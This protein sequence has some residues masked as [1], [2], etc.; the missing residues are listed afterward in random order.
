MIRTLLLTLL[1]GAALV[2]APRSQAQ[3]APVRQAALADAPADLYYV[4][5]EGATLYATPRRNT[6]KARIDFRT[7]VHLLKAGTGWAR[8]RTEDGATGYLPRTHISNVWIRVSKKQRTVYLYRGAELV[9]KYPADFG[10]NAFSDKEQVGSSLERD[11]W[12]TPEGTFYVVRK[13]PRSK[14]YKAFVL[15][16]PTVDDA[17]R[18]LRR[19]MINE[20][21]HDAIVRAQERSAMPPMN[22]ALGGWIE[23]HGDGTGGATDWTQGCVAVTNTHIDELWRHVKVGTPVLV[24]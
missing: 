6:P 19:G 16:Y 13:N 23:I 1:M 24:E 4:I 22:T 2:G 12:R 3:E 10:Y 5:E 21:E 17:A 9:K 8:V 18:G 14:F 11:H 20:A 7:P 15:N